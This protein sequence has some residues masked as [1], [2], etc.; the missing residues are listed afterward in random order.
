MNYFPISPVVLFG[1]PWGVVLILYSLRATE[2][3]INIPARLMLLL[4]VAFV[5]FNILTLASHI[6]RINTKNNKRPL[7]ADKGISRL[8]KIIKLQFYIW[9]LGSL[10]EV[11]KSAGI[12][13]VWAIV[14]DAKNYTDFG[15][16]SFHGLMNAFYFSLMACIFFY[17][18]ITAERKYLIFTIVMS[19]WPVLMLGRGIMLTVI[20]Q[21]MIIQIIFVKIKLKVIISLILSG[22]VVVIG[23]GVLGDTR[24]YAN[25]F[26][27]LVSPEYEYIFSTLPSGF[28]WVYTYMTSPLSNLAFNFDLLTPVWDFY[29][30]SVN[31]FPSFMRPAELDMADNFTF[32]DDS[33][34]VSTIFSSSHSDFGLVGDLVLIILL[35]AW[36]SFWYLAARFSIAYVLPY[37]IV[38]S[39]VCFSVFYNLFLLYPYLFATLLLGCIAKFINHKDVKS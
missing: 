4:S 38:G 24:G 32:V 1:L 18:K 19:C 29:Y 11:Y 30:S 16:H 23:F 10:Y 9:S 20:V 5:V 14:G 27:Y 17:Y 8:K 28:L 15:V 21:V 22:L 36:A 31:L 33:L 37:S 12:P 26:F 34:N 25:P 13:L 2:N 35:S 7:I 39:V 6:K 3:L